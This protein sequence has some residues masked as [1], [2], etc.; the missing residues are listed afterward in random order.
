MK[1]FNKEFFKSYIITKQPIEIKDGQFKIINDFY[2]YTD[3]QLQMYE[4]QQNNH[5]I[6]LGYA[7]DYKNIHLTGERILEELD[8]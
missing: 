1:I 3:E 2:I 7:V 4:Y 6:I 5:W 8:Q